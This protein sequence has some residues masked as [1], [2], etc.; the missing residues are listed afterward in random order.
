MTTN[1]VR[2]Y[3]SDRFGSSARVT[4]LDIDFDAQLIVVRSVVITPRGEAQRNEVVQQE[5]QD[6]IGRSVRLRLDQV[7]LE[8]G[9]GALDAQREE[10]R[11]AGEAAALETSRIAALSQALALSAGVDPDQVT[12]DREHRRASV[13]AAPLPGATLQTYRVLEARV[14]AEASGWDI[15]I[16]PPQSQFPVIAVE[17]AEDAL[18]AVASEAVLTSAWAAKRWNVRALRVPGLPADLPP[19]PN[20]G[21]R[22]ALVIG[23]ILREQ[24]IEAVPGPGTGPAFRLSPV[25]TDGSTS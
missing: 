15:V 2:S 10:L 22:R 5:L 16:V 24:G 8:P 11:Q 14:A 19:R 18:D 6:R 3:L 25:P 1:K 20:A 23:Q 13:V 7:L 12:V 4:Q 21:Q 17:G 9:A